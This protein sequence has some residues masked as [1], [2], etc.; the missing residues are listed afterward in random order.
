[1]RTYPT[2][3][4][5]ISPF[6]YRRITCKD[7]KKRFEHVIVWERHHGPVPSGME[8]HHINGDK[9]DNRIENLMLVNRLEHKRIESGCYRVDGRWWKRCRRCRWYRS[10]DTEF[11][12]YPGSNG[13]MGLCKR[14]AVEVAMQNKRRRT[15]RRQRHQIETGSMP[16]PEKTSTPARVEVDM[17]GAK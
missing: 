7:R 1:M 17:A 3:R 15:Q 12:T 5:S 16:A 13:V 10:V 9:L 14:C 11:Y 4:G 2:P 6:G 8:L